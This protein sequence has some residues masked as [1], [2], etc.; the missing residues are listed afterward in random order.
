M[1]IDRGARQILLHGALLI[2]VGLIWGLLVPHTPYPRL[3]LGAHI[4]F[5]TN[6]LLLVVMAGLL[7]QFRPAVGP[8]SIWAMLLSAW[9][10]WLMA[11]SEAANSW[12]GSN[13]ILA[14]SAAQAGAT[15]GKSWQELLLTL[16]HI[17]AGL[18]LIVAWGLLTLGLYR[19]GHAPD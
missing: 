5:L 13:Q 11:L 12:W 1:S 6:G 4:Q 19:R 10:I 16:T 3:A 14:I 17:C 2:L 18:V 9:L 15:G 8:R 7:L